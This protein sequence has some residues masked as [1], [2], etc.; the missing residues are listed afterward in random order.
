MIAF[1]VFAGAMVLFALLVLF[2]SLT[3]KDVQ[4]ATNHRDVNI[5]IARDRQAL[6]KD[7]F[8]KGH[9]DQS[10]YD[11]ELSDIENTLAAELAD[12]PNV[13]QLRGMRMLG[14]L[15]IIVLLPVSAAVLYQRL[16]TPKA[17]D[18]LY[19]DSVGALT[20]ASGATVNEQY[21]DYV[22]AGGNPRDITAGLPEDSRAVTTLLTPNVH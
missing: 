4:D 15:L 2:R 22:K 17:M 14:G 16:G 11:Q 18:P 1:Y 20:L 5:G 6:I 8:S 3:R 19:L 12:G 21:A 9:I 7:A 10:T 13:A